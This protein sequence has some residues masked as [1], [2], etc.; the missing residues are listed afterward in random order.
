M[1]DAPD[2]KATLNL[3]RT[4]FP[5]KADLPRREPQQL[6]A[7]EAMGLEAK[8]GGAAAA[9]PAPVP[10]ARR[11]ALRQRPDPPRAPR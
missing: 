10:P 5:M 9:G 6:A 1:A 8:L 7:W 4:E 11:A 3:P 2:Y